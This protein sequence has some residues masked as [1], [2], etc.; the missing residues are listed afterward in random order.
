MQE[1][2]LLDELNRILD[3]YLGDVNGAQ[4]VFIATLDGH[5]LV[6]RNKVTQ[7]LEQMVP[8][9]GSVLGISETLSTQ[10]LN[11]D[12]QDN[13]IVMEKNILGLLRVKDKEDSLFLGVLC[14]R[15]VNLGK[16]LNFGKMS[17]REIN[18]VL[19]TQDF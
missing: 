5:L 17:I 4:V 10:I 3:N 16:M 6:E 1:L 2:D 8:M 11:Q 9:A 13:I 12:L 7:S 18:K 15:V 14:D 19:E